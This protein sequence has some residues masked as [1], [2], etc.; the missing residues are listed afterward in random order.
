M[1]GGVGE[2]LKIRLFL[3]GVEVPV[4]SANVQVA[5][6]SPSVASIQV[7]P[8]A[9]GTKLLPRTLVHMFFDDGSFV[10]DLTM[11]HQVK[12]R[13]GGDNGYELERDMTS[14]GYRLCFCG[15]VV[16]FAWQ[17]H[18]YQ[19]SLV[20]QCLDLSCY[21][22][23]AFQWV[24]TDL[25]GPGYKAMFSGGGTDLF[26]DF[27]SSAG[28]VV[29]ATVQ[30]GIRNGT[31]Q[32]PKMKGLLGGVVHLLER[33]GGAY[34]TNGGKQ[35]KGSNLFFSLAELRLHITQMIGAYE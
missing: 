33:I 34:F 35:Y 9:E 31:W 3:E 24:N 4:V 11:F 27:L 16:G 1:S 2:R 28:E 14:A 8:L 13:P 6:N 17:K 26:T 5:P 19:R 15:E 18:P 10:P 21:W 25:F 7:P 20:L 23:T 22:D 29:S 30:Q 12:Q 32:Y